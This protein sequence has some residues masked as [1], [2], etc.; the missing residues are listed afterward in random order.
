M[1]TIEFLC[2]LTG[3]AKNTL[4]NLCNDLNI[5][6]VKGQV[7]GNP[8]K[9]MYSEVDMKKLLSYQTKVNRGATKEAAVKAILQELG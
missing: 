7:K 1:Y 5:T 3:Y 8:G 9:A 6:G 2:S 4:Y